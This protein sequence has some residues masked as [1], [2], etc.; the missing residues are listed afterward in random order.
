MRIYLSILIINLLL[1]SA[2]ISKAQQSVFSVFSESVAEADKAFIAKNYE[3]ALS[4]YKSVATRPDAPENIALRLAR[5]FYYTYQYQEA[6]VYYG[7]HEQT[8]LEFPTEDYYYYAEALTAI[9][10]TQEA[11]KYFQICMDKMPQNELFVQKIWRLNNLKYL[12]EDSIKNMTHYAA[13][14]SPYSELQ[15]IPI[16]NKEVYLISNRPEVALFKKIDSKENAPFYNLKK[17]STY[18]DPF[19]VVALNYENCT[20]IGNRLKIPF[21]FS[22]ASIYND[23]LNMV[24]SASSDEKN[25]DGNYP[26]QLYFAEFRKG[27]WIK[28]AS[29]EHN[30]PNFDL[31]EPSMSQD[32]KTLIFSANFS[33][34]FG[35]KDLY[36]SEKLEE[37]WS[38][39]ENLGNVINTNQDERYPF[40]Q[41]QDLFF[42][43]AGQP[44]LGGF[45]IYKSTVKN[46]KFLEVQNLGYPIN[47]SFDE[48][49]FYID[50]LGQQGFLSSNRKKQGFDFDIYEFAL[51]LQVYPLDVEGVVK[52]IEHNW[53]D[54]TELKILSQ[55]QMELI[56]RTGNVVIAVTETDENGK[57]NLKV[58][59][60]SKYKIRIKGQDLDGFVSFEVPKF[61]KQDLSYEI[62][63]VNDDFKNSL[64]EE[65]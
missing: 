30:D 27:K 17:W 55:V 26:L 56:D 3:K 22:A 5:S 10:E 35:G 65:K 16:S 15:M 62:V 44:G 45:D 50:D 28:V 33:E 64:R 25:T 52:F 63:V 7:R 23:R 58:P 47:S 60:Y 41:D 59:Y 4:I 19:S 31:A 43:S 29:Y 8:K 12:F 48:L 53:M 24:Y 37:G 20:P 1:L 42:S 32:G 34:G 11:L 46:Q 13:L 51:D 6:V 38:K 39:P 54:S 21:H 36:R 18:E 49:S 14:N 2:S 9:G 57:F 61:A 40:V